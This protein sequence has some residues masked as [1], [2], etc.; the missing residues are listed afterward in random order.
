MAR[1]HVRSAVRAP[2]DP[3]EG[4]RVP[5]RH[6]RG[7]PDSPAAQPNEA[8]KHTDRFGVATVLVLAGLHLAWRVEPSLRYQQ[9]APPF[10]LDAPFFGKFTGVPGGLLDYG[11]AA[12]AQLNF[13]N[14]LGAAA[15]ALLLLAVFLCARRVLADQ[16]GRGGALAACGLVVLLA[17][18]PGRYEDQLEKTALRLL[19]ALGA[20]SAWRM[21]PA[22]LGTARCASGW[23]LAV[24]VFYLAGTLPAILFV[25]VATLEE[26]L[27]ERQPW[28]ALGC[29]LAGLIVPFW[30]WRQAGFAPLASA[31]AWGRGLNGALHALA[32]LYV[33]AGLAVGAVSRVGR[34]WRR[35]PVASKPVIWSLACMM[36]FA[37]WWSALDASRRA[38]DELDRAVSRHEWDLALATARHVPVWSAPARLMLVRALAHTGRLPEDL[39]TYPQRRGLE[40]LPGYEAGLDA[41]RVEAQTLLD[42]GQVNLAE[43]MAHESLELDGARP[44]TLRLLARVNILKGRPEA[45]RVFLNRLRLAPFHRREAERELGLLTADPGGSNR[46]E[47]AA[48]RTRMPHTDEPEARLPTET[49]LRQLLQANPTNRM[50]FDFLLAHRLLSSQIED[51]VFE[52]ERFDVFGDPVLPRPCEEAVLFAR[53]PA[54]NGSV[55]LRGHQLR[56]ASVERYRRFSDRLRGFS[57]TTPAAR[58]ALAGEFGDTYWYYAVFGETAAH[59]RE[60]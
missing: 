49:L 8:G 47:L 51:L 31:Q 53:N 59:P 1:K 22:R 30:A 3:R 29:A 6:L 2:A 46:V 54:T 7:A 58:T 40:L 33:P 25:V 26:L 11:A 13:D 19:V 18:L 34:P 39:F 10:F 42:L 23:A 24:A 57:G 27:V 32:F 48:I 60:P 28:I 5:P 20:A 45:A 35:I 17:V 43:H 36:A 12:L 37:L 55:S 41:A 14:W 9:S 38:V 50:A 56:P 4:P 44:D 16:S 15:F 21:I 52:I